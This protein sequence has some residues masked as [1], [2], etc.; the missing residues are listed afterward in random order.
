MCHTGGPLGRPCK[1]CSV[2]API[3]ET[4]KGGGT[5]GGRGRNGEGLDGVGAGRKEE[6]EG[7]GEEMRGQR[8]T[9]R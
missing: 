3:T 2:T 9:W 5:E 7:E 4:Q 1:H 8:R 6:K